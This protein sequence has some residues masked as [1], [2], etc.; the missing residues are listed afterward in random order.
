[1][2]GEVERG[3]SLSVPVEVLDE[4]YRILAAWSEAHGGLPEKWQ[5]R[6]ANAAQRLYNCG[7]RY[8]SERAA[9]IQRETGV[10]PLAM[11]CPGDD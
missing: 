3:A 8:A 1:M 7:A 11:G 2:S 10:N 4:A 5:E 9:Q 6:M